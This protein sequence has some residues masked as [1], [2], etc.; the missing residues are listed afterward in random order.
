MYILYGERIQY[1]YYEKKKI[2][3]RSTFS[4]V[5]DVQPYSVQGLSIRHEL[6]PTRPLSDIYIYI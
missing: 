6:A 3:N 1:D 5:H 2:R 4:V